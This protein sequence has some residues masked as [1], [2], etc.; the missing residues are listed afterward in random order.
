MVTERVTVTEKITVTKKVTVIET[1]TEMA[2]ETAAEQSKK[3]VQTLTTKE[4]EALRVR[5]DIVTML[6][7]A[8]SGHPGGSLS[9]TEI[10][11]SLYHH[12]SV[13]PEEPDWEDRDRVIISKGH[14]APA[15]YAVLAEHGLSLIHIFKNSGSICFEGGYC[16]FLSIW[17]EYI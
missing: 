14:A 6:Y 1:A 10:L 12:I 7:E 9:I 17:M 8:G 5:Q 3:G 15:V 13:R 11:V 2:A 16:R 4:A